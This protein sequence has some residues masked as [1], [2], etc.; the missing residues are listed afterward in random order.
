MSNRRLNILYVCTHNRCR[1][2]LSEAVSNHFA[3]HMLNARSAGSHPAGQVHPES[4]SAL[5]AEGIATAGLYS[6]SWD[7][8]GD[9]I[10]DVVITVCDRAAGEV[11]PLWLG[12]T[13]KLHWG[14]IDPSALDA[15][16]VDRQQAFGDCI[17]LIRQRLEVL[18]DVAA[19]PEERWPAAFRA[20]GD[21]S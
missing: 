20:L 5:H 17:A 15:G 14:L 9:F 2:I 8:I 1:S 12:N 21:L 7:D 16:A 3:G 6:K 18:K 19:L 10:P 4:L 13:P 11:C